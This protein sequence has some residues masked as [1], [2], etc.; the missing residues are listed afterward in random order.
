MKVFCSQ[1]KMAVVS[2]LLSSLLGLWPIIATLIIIALITLLL[3]KNKTKK[4]DSWADG[5]PQIK[6]GIIW[7]NDDPS[8]SGFVSQYEDVYKAMKGLRYCLYYNGGTWAR[9]QTK[10][11][12]LDPDLVA[13][14]MIT[15]FDHFVDNTFFSYDYMKVNQQIIKHHIFCT[16]SFW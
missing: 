1:R 15:D 4:E 2:W 16:L 5:I 9:G 3:F 13:K 12:I 10:L 7:G 8:A 14:I 6:P 11:M